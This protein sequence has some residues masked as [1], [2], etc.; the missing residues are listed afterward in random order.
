[1]QECMLASDVIAQLHTVGGLPEW[2][3]YIA[4]NLPEH[5]DRP[6]LRE[7]LV[8]HT[9]MRNAHCWADVPGCQ[10]FIKALGF[11]QVWLLEAQTVNSHYRG[12]KDSKHSFPSLWPFSLKT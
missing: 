8:R 5:P 11:P 10:D 6:G 2:E 12:N 9:L 7:Q 4:M 3:V 1:M